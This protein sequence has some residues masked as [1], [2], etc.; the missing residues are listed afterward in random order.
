M[1]IA[2]AIPGVSGGT[3][4]FIT[5]IYE[6]LLL[7]I[8]SFTPDKL[9]LLFKDPKGFWRGIN[10]RFLIQLLIGMVFGLGFG[11][12]VISHLL[13]NHQSLLWALF[14]G[15]V[16]GSVYLLG[17]DVRWAPQ[18]IFLA[19]MGA[20]LAYFV[21]T[22]A[23]TSG[24]DHPLYLIMAGMIAI[25][26]LMLPGISGSFML[27][28]LGLYATIING[29]KSLITEQDL[30]QVLPIALFSLGALIGLF[31]FARVL[32]YCFK[33]FR[34]STMAVMI[35]VLI[36]SLNKLWPWKKITRIY[37][38]ELNQAISFDGIRL[39]DDERFKVLS[40]VNI[41]PD[42][43]SNYTDPRVL[44]V[45]LCF[46]GG[47]ILVVLLARMDQKEPELEG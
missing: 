1:G 5:G 37:D 22:L 16:L 14:F 39:T 19:L 46:L 40:E 47:I 9:R 24:S 42:A 44:F 4:A 3:I 26:A 36:G 33:R 27:L 2:E 43:Y 35:G 32:S 30:T 31:S 10:G 18:Q 11:I 28:L 12:I 17:K 23:P 8:K 20:V 29:L 38:K 6:E 21:T 7:T 13:E 25:S 15:L 34:Q 45:F 41:L